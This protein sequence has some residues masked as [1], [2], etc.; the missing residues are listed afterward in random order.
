MLFK[1]VFSRNM[2]QNLSYV[3]RCCQNSGEVMSLNSTGSTAEV[4]ASKKIEGSPFYL[5]GEPFLRDW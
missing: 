2:V 4:F 1:Y 3:D 5:I